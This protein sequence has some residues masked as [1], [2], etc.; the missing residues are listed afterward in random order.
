MVDFV[1]PGGKF[2]N[3]VYNYP[4]PIAINWLTSLVWI[5]WPLYPAVGTGLV[6]SIPLQT[7][8]AEQLSTFHVLH[9]VISHFQADHTLQIIWFVQKVEMP[10]RGNVYEML[11]LG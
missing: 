8:L 11:Y 4:S 6:F 9:W 10:I 5:K 2:F 3:H 7:F 1:R